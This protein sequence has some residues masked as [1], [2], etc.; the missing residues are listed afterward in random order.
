MNAKKIDHGLYRRIFD[1]VREKVWLESRD[2]QLINLLNVCDTERQQELI[3]DLIARF[4]YSGDADLRRSAA[5]IAETIRATWGLVAADTKI[6]AIADKDEADGSQFLTQAL[7]QHFSRDEGWRGANFLGQITSVA[8]VSS[9]IKNIVLVDDFIGTGTKISRKFAWTKKKLSEIGVACDIY[10][11]SMAAM[12]AS[13]PVLDS[14]GG[15]YFSDVWLT[16][17]ISDHFEGGT[18]ADAISDMHQLENKLEGLPANY[19]FGFKA[20]ESIYY[21]EPFNVPN[22]VF[23]IFWW[24]R[25]GD[26]GFGVPLF[27]RGA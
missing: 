24:E 17:G 25:W 18:L 13:R 7:R 8:S 14:L 4:H 26:L 3:F 10:M 1:L 27:D 22:N 11:C 16:R 15:K 2:G 9:D 19:C 21:H 6:I 12:E 5:N 20:S 23:P